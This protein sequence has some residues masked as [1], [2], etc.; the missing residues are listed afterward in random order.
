M[1]EPN[2]PLAPGGFAY[3][4]VLNVAQGILIDQQCGYLPKGVNTTVLIWIR[5]PPILPRQ[6][7]REAQPYRHAINSRLCDTQVV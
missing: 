1:L 5:G 6:A 7:D 2:Y 3:C 4:G